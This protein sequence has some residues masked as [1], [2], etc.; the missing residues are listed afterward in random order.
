[1]EF[2][3]QPMTA[4]KAKYDNEAKEKEEKEWDA[5]CKRDFD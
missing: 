3:F 2:S 4:D 5:D 1:M